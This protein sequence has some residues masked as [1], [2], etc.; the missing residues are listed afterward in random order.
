MEAFVES[1]FACAISFVK[2][3]DIKSCALIFV[4]IKRIMNRKKDFI[5]IIIYCGERNN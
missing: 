5:V 3:S 2:L 4:P 1:D